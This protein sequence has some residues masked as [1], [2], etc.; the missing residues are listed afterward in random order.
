MAQMTRCPHCGA[1]NSV[2]RAT[3]YACNAPLAAGD[4]KAPSPGARGGPS[5][6]FAAVLRERSGLLQEKATAAAPSPAPGSAAA[7]PPSYT[8]IWRVRRAMML[9]RQL[10]AMVQSALPLAQSL[11]DLAARG[12]PVARRAVRAMAKHVAAGG[13]LSDAMRG[14]AGVFIEYQVG[15]V[16]A[17][18]LAGTL[19]QALDQIA[20]DCEAEFRLRKTIA[21]A[22]LPAYAVSLMMLLILPVALVLRAAPPHPWTLTEIWSG[23]YRALLTVS[24]PIAVGLGGIWVAWMTAAR[25]RSVAALQHRIALYLPIVGGAY[26]RAGIMRFLGSLSL[27]LNAGVPIAEAYRSAA[28]ATGNQALTRTLLREADNLY[29]GRGLVDTLRRLRLLRGVAVDQMVIGETV[30]ELPKV[31]SQLAADYRRD[32]DRAAKYLPYLLQLVA[33][34]VIGPLAVLLWYTLLGVYLH[35]RFYAPLEHL[36]DVP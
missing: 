5:D 4:P 19:P 23:Y 6:R 25:S 2:R 30:G 34:A 36:F 17:A 10:H 22:L 9:F 8:G 28:A 12:D 21:L 29:A 20:A 35:L 32:V 16:Q 7:L 33:Y 14:Y 11:E 31:L 13:K 18:E 15:L 3:C 26:R 24:L 27:L 1:D